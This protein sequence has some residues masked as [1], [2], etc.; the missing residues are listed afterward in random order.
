MELTTSRIVSVLLTLLGVIVSG[1][2]VVV[3]VVSCHVPLRK[4]R[5]NVDALEY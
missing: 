2:V 4:N 5:A 3:I 1:G